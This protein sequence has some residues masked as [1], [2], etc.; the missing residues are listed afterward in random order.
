MPA[1]LTRASA[2]D[3]QLERA[4]LFDFH[5]HPR[6]RAQPLGLHQAAQ[7]HELARSE[8]IEAMPRA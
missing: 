3:C 8:R 2:I 6:A 7:Q 4:Q 5:A 1:A